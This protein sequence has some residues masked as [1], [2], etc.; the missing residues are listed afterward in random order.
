MEILEKTD[1]K[2]LGREEL[3]ILVKHDNKSTPK[4]AELISELAKK[5][6]VTEELVVVDKVVTGRGSNQSMLSVQIYNDRKSILKQKLA[7]MDTRLHGPKKKEPKA[8]K[9][10]VPKK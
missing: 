3:K 10:R 5:F 4:R 9:V 6:N 1:N 8:A 7:K 2:L